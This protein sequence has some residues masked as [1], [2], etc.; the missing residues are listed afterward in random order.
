MVQWWEMNKV[1]VT[2]QKI[3]RELWASEAVWAAAIFVAN[4]SKTLGKLA[5]LQVESTSVSYTHL[6]LPTKA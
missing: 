5:H 1:A 3:E 4:A 6:T 2:L